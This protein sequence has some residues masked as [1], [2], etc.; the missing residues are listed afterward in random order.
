MQRNQLIEQDGRTM[1][2]A[3]V[4]QAPPPPYSMRT[5]RG[6]AEF[7]VY[8][9][10]AVVDF[11]PGQ[12]TFGSDDRFNF[13]GDAD[14]EL[15]RLSLWICSSDTDYTQYTAQ[16]AQVNI[17][18]RDNA[19]GRLL[20]GDF[21]SMAELFGNGRTPFVLPTTHFFKRATSAQILYS[22]IDPGPDFENFQVIPLLIGRKHFDY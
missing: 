2:R 15:Q 7:Y 20:F 9:L 13:D 21:V 17:N 1:V 12:M 8:T 6:F 14:F 10:P 16:Y 18:I 19:T 5:R 22:P 11:T 4:G 3:I